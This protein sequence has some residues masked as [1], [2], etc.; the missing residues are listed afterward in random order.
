MKICGAHG[1]YEGV[2][3]SQ[4]EK[5]VT[6]RDKPLRKVETLEH[7]RSRRERQVQVGRSGKSTTHRDWDKLGLLQQRNETVRAQADI[8]GVCPC[9]K[10]E[11]PVL[12]PWHI[13]DDRS[14]VCIACHRYDRRIEGQDIRVC[15]ICN[16]D[17]WDLKNWNADRCAKCYNGWCDAHTCK[18]PCK[19][20]KDEEVKVLRLLQWNTQSVSRRQDDRRKAKALRLP[21][22][23]ICLECG[24]EK[25]ELV[26]WTVK[27]DIV[28]CRKCYGRRS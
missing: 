1:L 17:V 24:V 11:K 15:S 10:K 5:E 20:C 22:D 18:K 3:C 8:I 16:E 23:L 4:C 9:C 6:T 28:M 27:K 26:M 7:R 13:N 12:H 21:K 19:K 2:E 14:Y 25:R